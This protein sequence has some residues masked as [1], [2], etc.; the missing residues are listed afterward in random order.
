MQFVRTVI[1]DHKGSDLYRDGDISDRYARQE[2]V[3]AVN[4]E[5]LYRDIAGRLVKNNWTPCHR[6]RS[7]L[8]GI[9]ATQENSFLLGN[10]LTLE[11]QQNQDKLGTDFQTP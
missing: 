4:R 5:K 9:L 10:G 6:M 3:E 11:Q 2:N 1:E 7:K 8:F